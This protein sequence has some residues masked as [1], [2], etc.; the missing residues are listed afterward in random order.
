MFKTFIQVFIIHVVF[1]DGWACLQFWITPFSVSPGRSSIWRRRISVLQ[2]PG[3]DS[4]ADCVTSQPSVSLTSHDLVE[5]NGK[6]ESIEKR[7]PFIP[8][9]RSFLFL[10]HFIQRDGANPLIRLS[11]SFAPPSPPL[12][13]LTYLHTHTHTLHI[14]LEWKLLQVISPRL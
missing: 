2:T 14:F 4:L 13:T 1:R 9:S 12:I 10:F 3:I 5:N 7:N 11:Q 8:T 6:A